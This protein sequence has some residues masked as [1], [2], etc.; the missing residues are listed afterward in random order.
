MHY[1]KYKRAAF[2]SIIQR[3]LSKGTYYWPSH[4]SKPNNES[5]N[6]LNPYKLMLN[7]G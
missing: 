3:S 5:M 7:I 2:I 1:F 6:I 4:L